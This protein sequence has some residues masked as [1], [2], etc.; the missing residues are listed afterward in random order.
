MTVRPL[1]SLLFLM[2]SKMDINVLIA[3]LIFGCPFN[4]EENCC[5]NESNPDLEIEHTQTRTELKLKLEELLHNIKMSFDNQRAKHF[6]N[7]ESQYISHVFELK[8]FFYNS[9]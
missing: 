5:S 4:K 2:K 7:I 1:H 3:G 6:T 8:W 9:D